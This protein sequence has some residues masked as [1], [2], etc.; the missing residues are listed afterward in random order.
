[1]DQEIASMDLNL[2]GDVDNNVLWFIDMQNGNTYELNKIEFLTLSIELGSGQL[3]NEY[4]L[5][6][7]DKDRVDS[8]VRDIVALVP[9]EFS[10]CHNYPNPFNPSTTIPFTMSETGL[11]VITIYDVSG[12]EIRQILNE[13][14]RSGLHSAVWDGKKYNGVPVSSGVYYYGLKT[15]KFKSFKKMILI[16]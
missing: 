10:L 15:R 5:I 6:Y 12:R 3:P 4:K 11:A 13:R 9:K 7:G 2:S 1:M 14:V 8:I 16:K